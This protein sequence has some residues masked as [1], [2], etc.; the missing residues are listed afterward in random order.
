MTCLLHEGGICIR[1]FHIKKLCHQDV[2]KKPACIMTS[3][4]NGRP[5]TPTTDLQHGIEILPMV[6]HDLQ[7]RKISFHRRAFAE[8]G[9]FVILHSS[10]H[11]K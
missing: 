4:Q 8:Q 1:R 6:K 10:R 5:L 3:F 2:K 7:H 9:L 11:A